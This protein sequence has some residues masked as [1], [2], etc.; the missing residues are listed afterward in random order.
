MVDNYQNTDLATVPVFFDADGNPQTILEF[1]GMS[2]GPI[3]NNVAACLGLLTVIL[4]FF[5]ILGILALVYL[6]HDKH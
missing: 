6:R 2:D 4:T 3:M 1:Y 5:A